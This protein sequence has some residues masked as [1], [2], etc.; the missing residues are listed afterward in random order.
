MPCLWAESANMAT[1][2]Q[3]E[4]ASTTS[5][6]VLGYDETELEEEVSVEDS[7]STK[8]VLYNF[9]FTRAD[10]DTNLSKEQKESFHEAQ[11]TSEKEN[12]GM[13]IR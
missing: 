2:N 9:V 6:K 11:S 1:G 10:A 8:R 5:V 4:I 7:D 3:L 12:D 13:L